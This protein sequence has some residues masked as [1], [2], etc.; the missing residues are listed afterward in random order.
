MKLLALGLLVLTLGS[1]NYRTQ[2][3]T[4]QA[5]QNF[6]ASLS[7]AQRDQAVLPLNSEERGKWAYVPGARR[8]ISWG[9]MSAVQRTAAL[10]LLKVALSSEGLGKVEQIRELET[11]LAEIE[12]NPG[13]D[14]NR[15]W[16]VFFG[17]PSGDSPWV[18]RYEGHHVSLT[19]GVRDGV[20]VSSTPQFLGSN[21]AEVKAGR[22]QGTRILAKEQ[23]LGFQLVE[24]LN[25]AQRAK[26]VIA[27]VA[28]AD[29]VTAAS[30]KASIGGRMGVTYSELEPSQQKALLKLI[31]AHAEVQ[32][33]PEQKRRLA[34]LKRDGHEKLVFAWIGPVSRSGR[35]YYRIQGES[36][37]IEYD[38]TQDDGNH[39]HT[40]WRDLKGDFGDDMLAEH[41]AQGHPH[42]H[43]A[44]K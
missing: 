27:K 35:H 11:V 19:F 6:V 7:A 4:E 1:P 39:I 21:P 13:R 18:W 38:N 23:D 28:P 22:K 31:E 40:V 29:I 20:T 10:N 3:P 34:V 25:E 37:L 12:G 5:A 16:F 44:K 42:H 14:P 9:E 24:S 36:F 32:A 17:S 30:R 15:Y 43:P 8:G 33:K 41:Y 26:A 2:G